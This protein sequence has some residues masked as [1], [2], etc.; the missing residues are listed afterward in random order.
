[1]SASLANHQLTYG[2]IRKKKEWNN[3]NSYD[4]WRGSIIMQFIFEKRNLGIEKN[5]I[6]T[7]EFGQGNC[8]WRIVGI[9]RFPRRVRQTSRGRIEMTRIG[10]GICPIVRFCEDGLGHWGERWRVCSVD[11]EERQVNHRVGLEHTGNVLPGLQ[12]FIRIT[13]FNWTISVHQFSFLYILQG[14]LSR[15]RVFNA[16]WTMLKCEIVVPKN[17]FWKRDSKWRLN[18]IAFWSVG[19]WISRCCD[20]PVEYFDWT[21]VRWF[22]EFVLWDGYSSR[23]YDGRVPKPTSVCVPNTRSAQLGGKN[24]INSA[25]NGKQ[26]IYY[27][28]DVEFKILY[29]EILP[30]LT[31]IKVFWIVT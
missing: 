27:L 6:L 31:C 20:K 18:S 13:D 5:W 3:Y 7:R 29:E 11:Q 25:G 16:R 24:E 1:M 19:Y 15:K 10:C 4:E 28:F 12:P 23:H 22:C 26:R 14:F 21:G 9:C 17:H 8:I 30:L 2:T